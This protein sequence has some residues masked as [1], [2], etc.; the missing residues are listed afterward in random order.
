MLAELELLKPVERGT[1]EDELEDEA[2]AAET[3]SDEV[4]EEFADRDADIDGVA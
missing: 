3:R 2:V 1:E 4:D